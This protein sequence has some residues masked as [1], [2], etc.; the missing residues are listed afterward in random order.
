MLN[1]IPVCK[2]VD[3]IDWV[4]VTAFTRQLYALSAG[5]LVQGQS[6]VGESHTVVFCPTVIPCSP[7]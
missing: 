5:G 7:Q 2:H 3:V 4:V 6:S 1:F